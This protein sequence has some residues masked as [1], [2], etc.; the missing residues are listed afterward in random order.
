MEP[1]M[2][3][4]VNL[5]VTNGTLKVGDAVL[6][7]QY[8]GRVRALVNDH[9]VK[10]KS[11]GPGTP[12]KC[13]GIAGVPEAG[14]AFKVCASDKLAREQA[15]EKVLSLKREVVSVPR[16]ATL[17]SLIEQLKENERLELKLILKA[18]TQGSVEAITHALKE[19]QSTKVLLNIVMAGTGNITVNDVM[20]ASASNAVIMGFHVGREPNVDR[21]SKHEGVEIRLHSIIYELLDQVRD[22]MAGLLAPVIREK[23]MGHAEVKQVFT[24][25]KGHK[26]A[27]C[28]VKDGKITPRLSARVKRGSDVVFQGSI[29]SLRR[30]QNDVSEVSEGQ[31]CGM[32]LD[33]FG[34]LQPGDI[35]ECFDVEKIAQQL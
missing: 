3:P 29:A 6:C 4:T 11:V 1:G 23:V 8:A 20:L 27:G 14:A 24:I 5:L 15:A 26:V 13:L 21:T 7:E 25:S 34:D 2:G 12:V 33:S 35:I 17:E 16:K 18:D 32:R 19:I 31:E 10:V 22:A 28:T 9:G 30:F